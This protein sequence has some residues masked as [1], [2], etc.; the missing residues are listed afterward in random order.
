MAKELRKMYK[1]VQNAPDS[2]TEKELRLRYN[3]AMKQAVEMLD[4]VGE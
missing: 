2:K 1:A 3:K 4:E